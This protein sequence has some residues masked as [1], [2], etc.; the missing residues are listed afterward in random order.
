[1]LLSFLFS[2]S[3]AFAQ[4]PEMGTLPDGWAEAGEK[5]NIEISVISEE[6]ANL[7]FKNFAMDEMIPFKSPMACYANTTAMGQMAEEMG[8]ITG[9]V[10]LD[11][12]LYPFTYDNPDYPRAEWQMHTA[13]IVFVKNAKGEKVLMVLDPALD[14]KPISIDDWKKKMTGTFKGKTGVIKKVSFGSRFQF[15]SPEFEH[16]RSDWD[17]DDVEQAQRDRAGFRRALAFDEIMNA[18]STAKSP[19]KT[20]GAT[21]GAK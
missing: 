7:L 16:S 9:R 4:A 18:P 11:G 6:R 14:S 12:E 20:N 17:E 8:V 15:N 2:I 19:A 21:E 5:S 13:P 10:R 3:M 1:M